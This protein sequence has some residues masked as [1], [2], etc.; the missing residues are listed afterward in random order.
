MAHGIKGLLDDMG[1]KT[2]CLDALSHGALDLTNFDGIIFGCSTHGEG[3]LNP[4]AER[5]F[6][7]L[8]T[9]DVDF[10]G[11]AV[12]IFGLGESVYPCFCSSVPI[13]EKKFM[14]LG[15]RV[16]LPSLKIDMMEFDQKAREK[17]LIDWLKRVGGEF[18]TY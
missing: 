13:A 5:Y 2:V 1:H 9:K 17:Q 10:N 12:A 8:H 18:D 14:S 3:E 15:A 4:E 7:R 16:I 11:K 6:E